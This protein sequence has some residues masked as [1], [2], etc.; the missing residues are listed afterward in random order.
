MGKRGEFFAPSENANASEIDCFV[1]T[2]LPKMLASG[3]N[4]KVRVEP[5]VGTLGSMLARA[6]MRSLAAVSSLSVEVGM[7]IATLCGNHTR[8]SV[9]RSLCVSSHQM[10]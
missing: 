2:V 9:T 1:I 10:R 5:S 3:L 6:S 7:G 8:V 4:S